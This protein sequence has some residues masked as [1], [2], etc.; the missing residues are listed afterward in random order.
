MSRRLAVMQPYVFPYLGYFQLIGAVDRFVVFDDVHFIK[1]GWIHR[2][3]LLSDGQALRFTIPLN[4]ASQHKLINETELHPVEYA[5]WQRKFLKTLR[6]NY[7][8][9][10]HFES[11]FALTEKV[12]SEPGPTIATLATASLRAVADYLQL[13]TSL[14]LSSA[15]AY[16]RDTKG[17]EKILAIVQQQGASVY[18]NPPGGAALYDSEAFAKKDVRLQFIQPHEISYPQFKKPFVPNLSIID[19]MMF[20]DPPQIQQLL[21]QYDLTSPETMNH[22]RT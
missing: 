9:A 19:V 15:L 3:A 1:R 16:D 6:Q 8:S 18:I 22:D 17:Q 11:G 21:Q 2:N 20:N 13:S 14:V 12:L 10:P 7:K 5:A 4:R